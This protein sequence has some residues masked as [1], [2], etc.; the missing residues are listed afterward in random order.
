VSAFPAQGGGNARDAWP[1][2]R[3]YLDLCGLAMATSETPTAGFSLQQISEEKLKAELILGHSGWRPLIERAEGHGYFRGQVEFLL[4]FCGAVARLQPRLLERLIAGAE[5][6]IFLIVDRGPAHRAKK[7]QAFVETLGGKLRLFFLPPYSP[8]R[9]AVTGNTDCLQLRNN[10]RS[11]SNSIRHA[12]IGCPRGTISYAQ[13]SASGIRHN[14]CSCDLC[15][16][17]AI[18]C[19]DHSWDS[20]RNAGCSIHSDNIW[21]CCGGYFRSEN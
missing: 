18:W 3:D 20:A 8:D 17:S 15:S 1:R 11:H 13:N 12:D 10:N 5:R 19:M 6:T 14:C 2:D 9:M 21:D 4:D 16:W 7:T